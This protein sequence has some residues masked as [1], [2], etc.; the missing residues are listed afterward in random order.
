MVRRDH[1]MASVVLFLL[2]FFVVGA[3]L[4]L[5][6]HVGVASDLLECLVAAG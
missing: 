5:A 2:L 4:T 1:V 3:V 6:T